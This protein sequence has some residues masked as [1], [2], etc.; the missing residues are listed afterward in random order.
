MM[1]KLLKNGSERIFVVVFESG[2][3][4]GEGLTEF[5]RAENLTS[6]H[7]SAIGAFKDVVLGYFDLQRKDYLRNVVD[8]QV[9]VL[10]LIGNIFPHEDQPKLH[11]HV[12]VGRRD[13]A[14]LGGHLLE[15]TVRPTLEVIVQEEP[16]HLRRKLDPRT[17]LPLIDV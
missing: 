12:V 10:S 3:K 2:E 6:A 13:G 5:A 1:H 8:E 15:A 4:V 7:L 11:A 16:R 14:A 17:G 9:E